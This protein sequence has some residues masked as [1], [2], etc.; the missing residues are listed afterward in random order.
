[1]W[2]NPIVPVTPIDI[3]PPQISLL[4]SLE[5]ALANRPE[6][7]QLEVSNDI[8]EIDKKFF[9]EQT[10]PQIDFVAS[11]TAQGLAGSPLLAERN[12]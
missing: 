8:N 4:D 10:K 9:K 12:H 11:Y 3:E 7:N 1:M 2:K 6:I 5:T